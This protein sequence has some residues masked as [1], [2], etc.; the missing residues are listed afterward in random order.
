METG[1][2]SEPEKARAQATRD[3]R[4]KLRRV[5]ILL[6]L[7]DL[8]VLLF[9]VL[10]AFERTPWGLSNG[11]LGAAIATGAGFVVVTRIYLA[12]RLRARGGDLW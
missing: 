12:V 2:S 1:G 3:A 9:V 6:G 7:L 11:E 8:S 5:L 10:L 4:R